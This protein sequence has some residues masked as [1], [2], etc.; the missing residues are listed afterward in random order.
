MDRIDT[1]NAAVQAQYD[2]ST[3]SP[4]IAIIDAI[5]TLENVDPVGL[6]STLD[7]TLFDYVDPDALDTLVTDD[8]NILISF[9]IDEY[10]VQIDENTLVICYR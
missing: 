8:G 1:A 10:T 5:A 2:W 3:T 6:S 7:T 4:S 9:T